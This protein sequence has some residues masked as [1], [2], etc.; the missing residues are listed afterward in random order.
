MIKYIVLLKE[1]YGKEKKQLFIVKKVQFFLYSDDF[2]ISSPLGTHC[3][4]VTK[5]LLYVLHISN[6][7]KIILVYKKVNENTHM[8]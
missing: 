8:M 3:E 7:G 1:T 5:P 4:F 2:E 6:S